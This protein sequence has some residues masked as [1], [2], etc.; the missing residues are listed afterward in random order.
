M[1]LAVAVLVDATVVRLVL[2]PATM[3]L[4]GNRNWWL[5]GWLDRIV[6]RVPVEG[7]PEPKLVIDD[8]AVDP[9]SA[10]G[11]DD[12]AQDLAMTT[13]PHRLKDRTTVVVGKAVSVVVELGGR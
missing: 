1:G 10:A 4:L 8:A 9:T 12:D 6:P 3:E 2:V 13:S 5:P 7:R 11:G